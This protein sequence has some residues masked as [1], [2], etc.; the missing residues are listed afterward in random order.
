MPCWSSYA[1]VTTTLTEA[2]GGTEVAFLHEG[3]PER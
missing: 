1:S 2:N 3:I